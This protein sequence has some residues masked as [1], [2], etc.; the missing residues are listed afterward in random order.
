MHDADTTLHVRFRR[1]A[2]A[3]FTHRL[4]RMVVR[5]SSR[6]GKIAWDTSCLKGIEAIRSCRLQPRTVPAH[7]RFAVRFR[8]FFPVTR[9]LLGEFGERF[10]RGEEI[11]TTAILHPMLNVA[12]LGLIFIFGHNNIIP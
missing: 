5:R 8:L 12:W 6:C 9:R 1:E 3:A 2:A 10:F 11:H 4:E 7:R